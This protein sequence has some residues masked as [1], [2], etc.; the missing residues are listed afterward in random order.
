MSLVR[1]T[2]SDK[3]LGTVAKRILGK[4]ERRRVLRM[5]QVVSTWFKYNGRIFPWRLPSASE[6]EQIC[7]EVLLQRTRAETVAKQY[8]IF[9]TK[10]PNWT[11]LSQARK[12]DIENTIRPLGLWQRRATALLGLASYAVSARGKFPKSAKELEAVPAVGQY[13]GNAILLFQHKFP[14]PLLDANM[15]RVVERYF[16]P[17]EMADLR[18]DPWLQAV[19]AKLVSS[20]DAVAVNWG[21]LDIGSIL[22]KPQIPQCQKCPLKRGCSFARSASRIISNPC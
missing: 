1:P 21:I 18:Y 14:A 8:K 13:V 20:A 3:N 9:F 2:Q 6:Y 15:A 7:V 4:N 12:R 17:R 16:H 19:C 10:F 5:A 11:V 22:C